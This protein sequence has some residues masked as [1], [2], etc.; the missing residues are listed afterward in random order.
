MT[1]GEYF[2]LFRRRYISALCFTL[3]NGVVML[4]IYFNQ[5]FSYIDPSVS[6]FIHLVVVLFILVLMGG[7]R[8]SFQKQLAGLRSL[9]DK[10]ARY[11]GYRKNMIAQYRKTALCAVIITVGFIL[12]GNIYYFILFALCFL[13]SLSLIPSR[14]RLGFDLGFD[15]EGREK[16]RNRNNDHEEI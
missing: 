15:A 8:H 11:S 9:Q 10:S 12:T 2:K 16:L 1:I 7:G 14:I 3:L 13:F 6:F 4:L 5:N